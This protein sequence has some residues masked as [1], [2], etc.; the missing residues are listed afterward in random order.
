MLISKHRNVPDNFVDDVWLR[1]I[2]WV[3]WVSDILCG[4]EYP[5][6]K[7]IQELPL[8]QYTVGWSE[9][10]SCLCVQIIIKMFELWNV[11][12]EVEVLFEFLHLFFVSL[13]HTGL[14]KFPE[15]FVAVCPHT[16]L[17]L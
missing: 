13:T 6:S 3:R 8:T 14:V 11:F 17:I 4:T 1:G 7:G 9:S 5:M 12:V 16:I 10:K 15:L 2:L